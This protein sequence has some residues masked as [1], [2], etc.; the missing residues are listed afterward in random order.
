MAHTI[1]NKE[2]SMVVGKEKLI[3]LDATFKKKVEL[4]ISEME[5]QLT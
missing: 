5:K 1:Y 2:K 3:G 4:I